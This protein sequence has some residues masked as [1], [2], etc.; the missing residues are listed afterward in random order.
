MDQPPDVL[1]LDHFLPLVGRTFAVDG[2]TDEPPFSLV[3]AKPITTPEYP[4][5][6]REAF[7]LTFEAETAVPEQGSRSFDLP[8]IGATEIFLVPSARRGPT[9]V[10]EAVFN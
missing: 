6:L 8:G 7:A 10:Y 1:T 4:G 9:I 2:S 3:E 5:R